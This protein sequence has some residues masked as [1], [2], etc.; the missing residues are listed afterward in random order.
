MI[1][2]QTYCIP[3]KVLLTSIHKHG[4]IFVCIFTYLYKLRENNVGR[5]INHSYQLNLNL[6]FWRHN[7]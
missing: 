5:S 4:A 7:I 2:L 3:K 1:R 6:K